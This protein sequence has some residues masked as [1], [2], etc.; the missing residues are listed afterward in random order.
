M[1]AITHSNTLVG[2]NS[3]AHLLRMC[4]KLMDDRAERLF[5]DSE[6][7]L[8]QRIALMLIEQKGATTAGEIASNLSHSAGAITRTIDQLEARGLL[9]RR[10]E[11]DDRRVVT[12]TL[13]SDGRRIVRESQRMLNE[14]NQRIL[15]DFGASEVYV[16]IF[17]L[18]RLMTTLKTWTAPNTEPAPYANIG[19]DFPGSEKN[20]M[21]LES[22]K[23]NRGLGNTASR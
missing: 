11:M 8:T 2:V 21:L 15:A 3:P 16:L 19:T 14:F 7:S 12:L 20:A 6:I 17:L 9:K 18:K 10:R 4:A 23:D 5:D 13:T 22:H 1:Y